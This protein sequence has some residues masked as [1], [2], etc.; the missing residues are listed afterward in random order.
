MFKQGI[1]LLVITVL[2]PVSQVLAQ[3][4]V[5]SESAILEMLQTDKPYHIVTPDMFNNLG[6][7]LPDN[8]ETVKTQ[9]D[10]S[11]SGN[12]DPRTLE[13]MQGS[14]LGYAAKWIEH[15]YEMYGLEW[16]IT[17]LHLVPENPI[18][19]M[20]TMVLIHGGSSNWYEFFLDP[21]NN[22]GLG[23]YLAQKIPVL[24]VTIPG[25]YR[26][27]GWNEEQL[28]NRVPA[29][30]LDKNFT[31]DEIQ[32]RNTIFTFQLVS[33]GVR[34]LI[35]E[36]T[37]GPIAIIGHSTAGEIPYIL[38]GTSLSRR[39]NGRI[40]GWGSGGTSAQKAMQDRWGYAQTVNSYPAINKLRPRPIDNYAEDY[41]GPLNPVWNDD[42]SRLEIARKWMGTQEFQ[43]RPHFKQPLQ[44]MER[45]GAIP[46]MQEGTIEQLE[47]ILKDNQFN[48]DV[49]S[50]VTDLF[51]P[52]RAPVSNYSKII[53]TTA[54]LDTGHWNKN[55]PEQ[56]STLQVANELRQ[57]NPDAQVR[58]MLFD[59]P[60]THYGHI[61]KPKQ[62]AAGL[63]AALVWLNR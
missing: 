13:S 40:L 6:W 56:A 36:T 48:V 22:P 7:S 46:G 29:Y 52:M 54:R 21:L 60:M 32:I 35:E 9:A 53:L 38:Q 18:A 1:V 49:E 58:V 19:N 34:Q 51:A 47:N 43:R 16:D 5:D 33:E 23:Q 8:G 15:R 50:V 10:S 41:L 2:F 44:D 55:M 11:P 37:S 57:L 26:H 30:L 31:N 24:I 28:D 14:T 39:M 4:P 62:L 20:P 17:G 61:E 45:R 27:G 42:M 59:V 63:Y 12:L 25:N 3:Q